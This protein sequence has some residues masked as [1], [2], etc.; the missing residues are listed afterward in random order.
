MGDPA[1]QLAKPNYKVNI[2]RINQKIFK[3]K[4]TLKAGGKYQVAGTIKANGNVLNNFD[5]LIEFTLYDIPKKQKTLANVSSSIPVHVTTQENIL[6]KGNAVVAKGLFTVDFILPKEVAI[7]QGALRMQLYASNNFGNVDAIGIYDSLFVNAFSENISTDTSGPVFEK[8]FINDTVNEYKQKTWIQANSNLYINL[9]DSS[10]IQT[11]GNS[12]GHDISLVIDGEAQSPIILNNYYTADVNTYQS[13]KIKYA[14]PTLS[15]GV[16]QLIIKAWD[17]I[18]NS[19]KDT[20][21]V[22]VPNSQTLMVKNLTNY[23]N[24]V[25]S[26]TRFSFEISQLKEANKSLIYSIEIYNNLGIKQLA[27]TFEG[28]LVNRVVLSNVIDL[29][30]LPAGT[31]FY[32]LIVKDDQQELQLSN[33]FIKY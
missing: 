3:G 12:L 10:G 6:F 13:G 4:D 33:K 20:L 32:K 7:N 15:A 27:K 16:H 24:P 5:G 23:P 22:I 19:N 8:V 11:S 25:Q 29:R 21:N 17:L 28:P 9:K 30:L 14:L 26:S 31:Y 2:E 18:G 1:M